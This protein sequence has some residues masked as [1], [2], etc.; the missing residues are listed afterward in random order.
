MQY[1]GAKAE[2]VERAEGLLCLQSTSDEPCQAEIRR[3]ENLLR[4]IA[5]DLLQKLRKVVQ[6]QKPVRRSQWM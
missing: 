2:L 5:Q 3:M 4:L 6:A 1:S